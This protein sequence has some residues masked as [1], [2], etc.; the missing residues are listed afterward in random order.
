MLELSTGAA[1]YRIRPDGGPEDR[2]RRR[3]LVVADRFASFADGER[4]L[5]IAQLTEQVA[6]GG[7]AP[8][9]PGWLLHVGQGVERCDVD[10][11]LDAAGDRLA[12]TSAVWPTP[13]PAAAVHKNRAENVL[14]AGLTH[15]AEL[16]CEADVRVHR[17]NELILDHSTGRHLS[18]LVI[19]EAMRQ[20]CTAHFETGYR[21]GLPDGAYAGIWHRMSLDFQN[22]LFVLP[23]QV[24]CDVTEM[25][26]TRKG[27]LRLRAT[28]AVRQNDEVVASAGM[29]YSLVRSQRVDVLERH[30]AAQAV[31]RH[32]AA[33]VA[34]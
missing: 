29:E 9:C 12:G 15:P 8:D 33:A 2:S 20:L 28:T 19:I 31:R 5:T 10:A 18:G 32:L 25:D 17:D 23:A 3:V 4:V 11:L 13:V 22:F 26:L 34:A 21:C 6:A 16:R 24:T 7:A 14:L 1:A 27:Q 30:R